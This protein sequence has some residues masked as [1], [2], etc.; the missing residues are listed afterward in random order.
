MGKEE[1]HQE[2]RIPLELYELHSYVSK[3]VMPFLRVPSEHFI[4]YITQPCH[5]KK[6]WME[7][8]LEWQN[9]G[10]FSKNCNVAWPQQ[11]LFLHYQEYQLAQMIHILVPITFAKN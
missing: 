2:K 10:M 7:T 4:F 5:V 9:L 1:Q 6:R 8:I 3:T 11:L